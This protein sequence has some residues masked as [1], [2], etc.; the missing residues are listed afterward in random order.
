SAARNDDGPRPPRTAQ[1]AG[2]EALR[3]QVARRR[4]EDGRPGGA[5]DG[6]QAGSALRV[7]PGERAVRAGYRCVSAVRRRLEAM[8]TGDANEYTSTELR[9]AHAASTSSYS[10]SS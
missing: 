9:S 2:G 4:T 8:L 5:A 7:Q 1:S 10:A 6:P 3:R